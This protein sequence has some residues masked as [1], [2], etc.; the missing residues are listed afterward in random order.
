MNKIRIIPVILLKNG[1][2]VQSK[3]FIRHQVLGTP[4]VI[5][6]RLTNWF[7]DELIFLDIS[8]QKT[9]NL[10]RDDL[11]FNNRSDILSIIKDVSK[12]SFMPL[13][14]GG[15]IKDLKDIEDRLSSGADK[16][17]INSAAFEDKKFISKAVKEFGSQCIVISIDSKKISEN[18]WNTF[19]NY[20][21]KDVGDTIRNVKIMEDLGVGEILINSIDRDGQGNGMD[22]TLNKLVINS[23]NIPVVCMG[24]VG[25]WSHFSETI[26][27]CKPSGIAA[28]N[29]FQ[30]SENSIY[31]AHKYLFDNSYN[32]RKYDI[33]TIIK[34]GDE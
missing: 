20:G 17:T 34:S 10:N 19:T 1:R 21:K 6:G 30:Y 29:I 7:A 2:I 18:K 11:N 22:N 23:I 31:K 24:G 25:E 3:N 5:V 13:N 9:Y 4:T 33:E 8:R 26:D 15:G 14:I 27:K 16:V 28:A 32:V 12:K